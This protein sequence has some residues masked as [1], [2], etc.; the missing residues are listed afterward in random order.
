MFMEN[1]FEER[2]RIG[3]TPWDHGTP[4]VNLI[5]I[6]VQRPISKCKALDVGCGTGNNA[7]WLAQQHFEVTGCDISQTAIEEAKG[8]ASISN[9]SCSFI[10]A[11]F[12]NNR[13]SGSPFGFV[14]D[15]G[16]LHSFDTDEERRRFAENVASHLEEGGLWLSLAGNADEQ[17]RKS[18][19]P[20]L[21]AEELI[22]TVEPYCEIISLAASHFG[23][24][25]P[26]PAKAWVC[27]MRKRAEIL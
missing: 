21:T 4:D 1:R 24:N 10:V 3:D 19:P 25:Q 13:I 20:Q 9:I 2:Y 23:S 7:I 5:D 15:R 16:C 26:D 14:F 12:L 8:R 27:L 17:D 18:G 22:A 11:D 6:V